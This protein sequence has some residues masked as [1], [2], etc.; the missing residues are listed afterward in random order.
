MGPWSPLDGLI[1]AWH[2]GTADGDARIAARH[3]LRSE[4]SV[5]H[6]DLSHEITG[7]A[8]RVYAP[9]MTFTALPPEFEAVDTFALR[10]YA[11]V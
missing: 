6:I 8:E 3:R 2:D 7:A 10:S 5:T 4:A 9:S 11:S 1:D